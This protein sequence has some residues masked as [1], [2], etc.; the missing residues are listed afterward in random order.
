VYL[1]LFAELKRRRV[2]RAL[3]GYGIAAFAV[4]QIVEPVMHGL[5][6]PEV[7][8]SYVVVALAIGFPIVISLAWIFDVNA[9]RLER[10]PA[11]G[12]EL[13]GARVALA[14]TAIGVLAATPGIVWYFFLRGERSSKAEVSRAA[15]IAVLPFA[16]LSGGQENEYF[17][18]GVTE[19]IINALANVEGVRV[20]A[21]TSAFSFKGKNVNVRQIGEELNVG[22]VLEGSVRREGNQLR[23]VAQLIG[24]ADGYHLWSRTYDRELKG[25]FS[26]EDE[27]A[28]AIVQALKPRLVPAKA[29]VQQTTS[30]AEAHD[31]YLK[32]RYF[33]N[34]RSGEGF[35]KAKALFEKA[36]ALDPTY[37]LAHSGL[38]DCYS[39]SVDYAR[40]RTAEV[41]PK[42]RAHARKAAELDDS[43]AEAHT[44]LGMVSE[45]DYDWSGA[46][47]EYK[48]A[49]ELKPGYAT[50][51]HWYFLLLDYTGHF[52][53]AREE[54][55]RARQL[56]P[57][58]AIINGALVG[59]FLNSR[60][61]DRAIEQ[62]LKGIELN[63]NFDLA[64]VWLAV[65]YRYA[66]KISDAL[67]ALDQVRALP[68]GALRVQLLEAA[69]DRVAAQQLLAEVEKRFPTEVPRGSL[70]LAHLALGDVDG[71]FLWLERG[72]EER[73]QTVLGLKVSP[74]WDPIRAD[75]RY[76]T[77]LKR[78]KLE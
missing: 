69:G 12:G 5:H 25:V 65:S 7:T 67:A 26:L 47:R 17:S 29:L 3:V 20:V 54:A 36:I 60:E 16:N 14:L 77:L 34:Q 44:S 71:A 55:E 6:W 38:A 46:E 57:T 76:H 68:T 75:P 74:H 58:S 39:L 33:W 40:A 30:S 8:L 49:I 62:A 28:R 52:A 63:P 2:F 56:D 27:L 61:Y 9:G 13:K 66:G 22:T 41:L 32:G 35:A 45:H 24:A 64:R 4:L 15:S 23:V 31:L 48:R 18:D 53:E 51:H 50:A 73:D 21:R 70:A 11:S 42:A 1:H 43:L 72:V 37:A 59:L 78:M 19:E 10:T